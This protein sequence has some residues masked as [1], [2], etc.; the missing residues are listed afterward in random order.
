[1]PATVEPSAGFVAWLRRIRNSSRL[2]L[3]LQLATRILTSLL[4]LVWTKLLLRTMGNT[5]NGLF[6]NV[7]NAA[8]LG[9]VGDLGMGGA[10]NIQTGQYLGKGDQE[11]LQRFLASARAI[12]LTLALAV[13][14]GFLVFMPWFATTLGFLNVPEGLRGG[15][16]GGQPWKRLRVGL[17]DGRYLCW[18]K[19]GARHQRDA[20]RQHGPEARR[21]AREQLLVDNDRQL[22]E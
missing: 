13:S 7:Q 2:A 14:A 20:G 21:R 10:I 19:C 9:G 3:M 12:F 17:L 6:L 15:L 16:R 22:H 1:M 8:Q 4:A 5:L 11:E 18:H